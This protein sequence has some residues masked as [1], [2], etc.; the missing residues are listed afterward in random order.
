MPYG[1][2]ATYAELAAKLQRPKTARAVGGA[3]AAN[4]V[5]VILPCHRVIGS[6]GLTG[7]AGGLPTKR[8]LLALE[9]SA[10]VAP[11]DSLLTPATADEQPERNEY[12]A[13]SASTARSGASPTPPPWRLSPPGCCDRCVSA[14]C[15]VGMPPTPASLA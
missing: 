9:S 1:H 14:E 5:C 3:L 4:P 8:F 7:Y 6:R 2:T 13:P 10:A 15:D 11:E 12:R